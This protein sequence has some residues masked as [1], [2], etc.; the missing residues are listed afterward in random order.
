MQKAHGD[1]ELEEQNAREQVSILS[2]YASGRVE[3]MRVGSKT[4]SGKQVRAALGL[5]SANLYIK[6]IGKKEVKK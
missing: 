1:L 2:R 3:S 5:N 4:L 6:R